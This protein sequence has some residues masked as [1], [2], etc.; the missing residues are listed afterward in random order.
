MGQGCLPIFHPNFYTS[1]LICTHAGKWTATETL[2][3]FI[4]RLAKMFM[5]DADMTNP[6]S[7]ANR[8][9]ARWYVNNLSS[10]LFPTD[11]CCLPTLGGED[12]D[13]EFRIDQDSDFEMVMS[14]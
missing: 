4:I 3:I 7:P 1:G 10:G 5:F 11:N 2:P 8:D 14:Q 6:A 13:F 9:A 12:D